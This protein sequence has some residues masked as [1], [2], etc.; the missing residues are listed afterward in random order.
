MHWWCRMYSRTTMANRWDTA[1]TYLTG[2]HILPRQLIF[3]RL[4]IGWARMATAILWCLL[5]L[6]PIPCW[7]ENLRVLVVLSDNSSPY[8]PLANTL[9]KSFP[10]SIQVDVLEQP[11]NL[12]GLTQADLIVSVG[13]KASLSAI[14]R[15]D[16]PVL[17]VMLPKAGYEELLAQTLPQKN[18]RTISVI[19]LD[20]PWA[21]QLDFMQAALPKHRR[22][23]LLYSPSAHIDLAHLQ[24]HVSD[25]GATLVAKPVSSAEKLFS[26]LNEVLGSCDVLL[27]LPDNTIYNSVNIRNILLSSYRYDIPFIG[28]SQS[29]VTAGALGAIFSSQQQMSDQIAATI[30]SFARGGKLPDPQYPHDF[31]I[32]LNHEVAKSLG[33]E[34]LPADVI[35]NKMHGA[36]RGAP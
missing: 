30:L 24:K 21:R 35:R 9:S 15:T 8:K 16:I 28:L 4:C 22:I 18:T 31:T 29:Y 25:R 11:E 32:S 7:S 5:A 36:N 17:A 3:S 6:A 2:V 10:A 14:T 12:T 19:Y 27:A 26:T 23:G 33:I 1:A 13:M 34:L 20:Q